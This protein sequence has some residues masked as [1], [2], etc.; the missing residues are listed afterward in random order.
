MLLNF[1]SD[2][3]RFLGRARSQH[4]HWGEVKK[5]VVRAKD[6]P[7]PTKIQEASLLHFI[8]GNFESTVTD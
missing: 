8:L 4:G 2:M 7:L 1:F 5:E 3:C 6:H